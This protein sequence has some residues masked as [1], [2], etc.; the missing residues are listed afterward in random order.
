MKTAVSLLHDTDRR[1]MTRERL[2]GRLRYE[3]ANQA[4]VVCGELDARCEHLQ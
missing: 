3:I 2:N 1:V 4:I